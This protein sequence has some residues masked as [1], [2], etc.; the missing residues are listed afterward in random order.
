MSAINLNTEFAIRLSKSNIT[1]VSCHLLYY[2]L[3]KTDKTLTLN[4]TVTQI[5]KDLGYTRQSVHRGI[6]QL[7]EFGFIG[8]AGGRFTLNPEYV[9]FVP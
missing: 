7:R 1:M 9:E 3:A 2:L 6:N 5:A 4:A 8:Y